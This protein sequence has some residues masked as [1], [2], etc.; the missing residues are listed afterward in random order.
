MAS[1]LTLLILTPF[2]RRSF[3]RFLIYYAF[4]L[5]VAAEIRQVLVD[6]M[7]IGNGKEFFEYYSGVQFLL[8][9][10]A[11]TLLSGWQRLASMFVLLLF[12]IY[13]ILIYWFWTKIPLIYYDLI[14][15]GILFLVMSFM[16]SNEKA[17]SRDSILV[18]IMSIVIY[19]T[20]ARYI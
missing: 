3:Q 13:N 5:L 20:S 9:L 12:S 4:I 7:L 6:L 14:S 17:F 8:I 19:Y 18:L 15:E 16:T 1:I 10:G 2:I 11:A